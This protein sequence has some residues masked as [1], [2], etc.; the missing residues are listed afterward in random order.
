MKPSIVARLP[1]VAPES[2]FAAA[3][4]LYEMTLALRVE[5]VEVREYSDLHI[6]VAAGPLIDHLE[7]V[8]VAA[9]VYHI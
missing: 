3:G 1:A 2:V 8:V 5:V 9:A 7:P 4:L 6:P